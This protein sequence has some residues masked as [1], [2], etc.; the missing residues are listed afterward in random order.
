MNIPD[1]FPRACMMRIRDLFDPGSKTCR[2]VHNSL[3]TACCLYI[4][5]KLFQ[6]I[7]FIKRHS[8]HLQPRT[9]GIVTRLPAFPPP[10]PEQY[11]G[12][13]TDRPTSSVSHRACKSALLART[14]TCNTTAWGINQLN[15]NHPP[16]PNLNIFWGVQQDFPCTPRKVPTTQSGGFGMI[17]PDPHLRPVPGSNNNKRGG[18]DFPTL[19]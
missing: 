14:D 13:V 5:R 4:G 9:V 7:L 18:G 15:R 10:D 16:H 1:H 6:I 8:I 19:F 2:Q 12:E 17:I 11:P 3:D